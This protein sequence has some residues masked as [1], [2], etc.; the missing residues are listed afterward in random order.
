MVVHL[1]KK[2]EMLYL[3]VFINKCNIAGKQKNVHYFK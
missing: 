1:K 2:K 3:Y